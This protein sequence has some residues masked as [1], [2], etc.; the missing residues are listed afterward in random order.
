M[1]YQW[2]SPGIGS[3]ALKLMAALAGEV[4][5]QVLHAML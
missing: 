2:L 1:P 3:I 4:W 5:T